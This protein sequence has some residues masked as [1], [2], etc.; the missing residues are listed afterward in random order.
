MKITR[1]KAVWLGLGVL[2]GTALASRNRLRKRRHVP[3]QRPQIA[4]WRFDHQFRILPAGENLRVELT[5]PAI[6]HWTVN[7]WDDVEDTR[8]TEIEPDV[9]VADLPAKA[10][11]PG[12]RLQFTLYWPNV[13]R[14]EGQDFEVRVEPAEERAVRAAG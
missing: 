5:S 8:T 10:L 3:S 13:K 12:S 6:V 14:W 9:H 7:Q 11:R 4:T 1:S 2:A